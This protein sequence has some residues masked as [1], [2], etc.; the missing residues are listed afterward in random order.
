MGSISSMSVALSGLKAAQ[1]GLSV[2][3]HNVSNSSVTGYT[4]QQAIQQDFSYRTLGSSPVG[5][6]KNQAGLGTQV[7]VIRQ[8]RNKFYD[9]NYREE[10][11]GGNFYA[12]KYTAGEEIN[13]II[14]ELQSDYR[15]QDAINGVWGAVNELIKDP[16]AIET[17]SL[18][19]QTSVTFLNKMKDINKN[20]FEYQLNLNQQVKEEVNKINTTVEQIARLNEQIQEIECDGRRANDLRDARN[21][22]LDELSG[23]L[24]IEVKESP[25]PGSYASRMDILVNGQELLVNNIPNKIGLKYAN[26]EYPFYEPVFTQSTEILPANSNATKLFPNLANEDL[27]SHS[28]STKGSLKGLLISRGNTVGNYTMIDNAP[29]EVGNFLIPEVQAKIDKLVHEIVT[30]LNETAIG[31]DLNG[32]TGVPIF[33]RKGTNDSNGV[34]DP[35]NPGNYLTPENA[36]DYKTLFTLENIEINPELLE[37]DG[38]NKLG[39]SASGDIGDTSILEQISKKWKEATNNLDGASIDGYYKQIITDFAV[40]I[41]DARQRLNSKIGTIDLAEN[42]RYALSAVSLDEELSNMLKFQHAYNSAA[43]VI[44]VID[45]M[46]DK[47]INGTGRVGI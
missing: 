30:L 26:G 31:K 1:A 47:V 34:M 44:N 15:A 42:Q 18:F 33:V 20:L 16:G 37:N 13:N 5:S 40:E 28:S 12:R 21:L 14:G 46:L 41:Q 11:S 3:G 32:N 45:S 17:R 7:G 35:N 4:R 24:D 19:I 43:K 8:L 6:L 10:N 38:Y 36:N 22:L 25:I 27:S 23:Y 9:A 29:Q 39:F 2:T